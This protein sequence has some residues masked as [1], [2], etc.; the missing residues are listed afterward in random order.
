MALSRFKRWLF[1]GPEPFIL[2]GMK[3]QQALTQ[4]DNDFCIRVENKTMHVHKSILCT[5]S[6]YFRTMLDSG[7]KESDKG[8]IHILDTKAGI[9]ET[10]IGYFYGKDA[11]IEWKQIRDYVD[12]VEL[13]QL[14]QVK[15]LLEAYIAKNITPQDCIG[16]LNYADVYQ[17]EHVI[18][19]IIDMID[20]RFSEISTS[21][22]FL[23]LS[24]SNLIAFI[25][26]KGILHKAAI[27]EGCIRWVQADEASRKHDF[28][29]LMRHIRFNECNRTYLKRM[30]KT[31]RDSL[32]ED[33]AVQELIQ[34][35]MASSFILI[36]GY[37]AYC[38][39]KYLDNMFTW[40][41]RKHWNW[42]VSVCWTII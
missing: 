32:I 8:E 6:N 21:K 34:H 42:F 19:K 5:A 30:L 7:M 14:T 39:A 11:Y 23:A 38:D 25:S 16:W 15:P 9:V 4:Q 20:T 10:M 26:H 2:P 12:I 28:S 33:K 37:K 41:A 18:S 13:W 17:L 1:G 40:I 35:A 29:V 31:H 3:S 36:G 27:L 24:L 22:E